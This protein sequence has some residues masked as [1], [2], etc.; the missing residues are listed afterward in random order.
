MRLD[1]HSGQVIYKTSNTST[2]FSS[3]QWL[4]MILATNSKNMAAKYSCFID[5]TFRIHSWLET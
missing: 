1:N 2:I 3:N 4:E 5:Q